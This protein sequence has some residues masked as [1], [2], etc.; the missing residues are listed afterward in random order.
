MG[1]RG[2]GEY[3]SLHVQVV[4]NWQF[5]HCLDLWSE[6]LCGVSHPSLRPLIYPLVQITLGTL[7]VQPSAKYHPLRLH[8]IKMLLELSR[9]T[10][11]YIPVASYLVEVRLVHTHDDVSPSHGWLDV[12]PR[13]CQPFTQKVRVEVHCKLWFILSECVFSLQHHKKLYVLRNS[14]QH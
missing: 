14:L 11:T 5:V 10:D 1:G 9:S 4:Y 2:T 6:L 13:H 12:W 8:L 3:V 7:Q